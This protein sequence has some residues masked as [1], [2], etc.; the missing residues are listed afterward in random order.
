MERYSTQ[1]YQTVTGN[2]NINP[3]YKVGNSILGFRKEFLE[4]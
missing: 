2:S 4:K 3:D 1:N